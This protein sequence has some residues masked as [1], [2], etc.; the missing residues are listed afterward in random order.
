MKKI[1]RHCPAK[2][3]LLLKILGK[4]PDHFHE[5]LTI[6]QTI[7]L[8]DEIDVWK[9]KGSLELTCQDPVI[10]TDRKN[11]MMQAAELF[12]NEIGTTDAIGMRLEKKIPT[13]AGLGGGSSDAAHTLLA[14]NELF[15]YPLSENRLWQ[16]A[17]QLGSDIPFF[18][19][20]GSA[21]CRGRG[22]QV[23]LF[24]HNSD[25]CLLL[26]NPALPLSTKEVYQA[27]GPWTAKLTEVEELSKM[28][29]TSLHNNHLPELNRLLQ[30]DLQNAALKKM[31][32]LT[33]I[34]DALKKVGFENPLLSGSGPTFFALSQNLGDLDHKLTAARRLLPKNYSFFSCRLKRRG[35]F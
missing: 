17:A 34:L 11:L 1:T 29:I 7:D 24:D 27:L 5:L 19:T 12:L 32:V 8:Q 30:N 16:I 21:L 26:V 10:P 23:E 25:F 31:P 18:L 28:M 20:G 15:A 14:L 22:E 4:R 6:M 9:K 2:V 3:N 13:A 35:D 33:N